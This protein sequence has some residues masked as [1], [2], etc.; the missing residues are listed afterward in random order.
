MACTV[1]ITKSSTNA[2][3]GQPCNFVATITNNGASAVTIPSFGVNEVSKTGA[4]IA[5]PRILTT[6]GSVGVGDPTINAAASLSVPFQVIP[7]AP[8]YPGPS[9][10]NVGGGNQSASAGPAQNSQL[11]LQATGMDSDDLVFSGQLMV[12][13]LSA[14]EVFPRPEGGALDFRQG[15]NL[16]NLLTL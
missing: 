2:V 6:N 1:V 12:P 10:Q 9:P 8:Q 4:R 14:F 15:S 5:Q 16:I 3:A 7:N 11:I 13:V